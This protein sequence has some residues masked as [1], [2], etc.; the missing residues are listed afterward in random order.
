MLLNTE[1]LN[2]SVTVPASGGPVPETI[3]TPLPE[4]VETSV[5]TPPDMGEAVDNGLDPS[6]PRDLRTSLVNVTRR[7][8]ADLYPAIGTNAMGLFEGIRRS[9][10]VKVTDGKYVIDSLLAQGY[11]DIEQLVSAG[12]ALG[13]SYEEIYLKAAGTPRPYQSKRPPLQALP[14]ER[15]IDFAM[16][17]R[18]EQKH[19][20]VED[21]QKFVLSYTCDGRYEPEL[22]PYDSASVFEGLMATGD[23]DRA[24]DL[25]DFTT[26]QILKYGYPFNGM[27]VIGRNGDNPNDDPNY[28]AFRTQQPVYVY[29][30][31]GMAEA[32]GEEVLAHE[33]Y[34]QALEM[35]WDHFNP[36]PAL[37]N[38]RPFGKKFQALRRGGVSPE[39]WPFSVFGD[40]TNNGREYKDYTSAR[41]ESHLEDVE[42]ARQAAARVAP[43]YRERVFGEMLVHFAGAAE[44]GW[45]MSA[46]RQANGKDMS[47]ANTTNIVPLE[48]QCMLADMA[49]LLEHCY[50]IKREAAERSGNTLDAA[51]AYQREKY[52]KINRMGRKAFINKYMYNPKTRTFHDLELVGASS[53]YDK[54]RSYQGA[55]RTKV[56]SAATLHTLYSDITENADQALGVLDVAEQKLYQ[57]GGL[58]VGDLI[59]EKLEQWD[60]IAGWTNPERFGINGVVRAARRYPRHRL[61][62]LGSAIDLHARAQHGTNAAF[63]ATGTMVE[64]INTANPSKK[65]PRGEYP[66]DLKD[67]NTPRNFSMRG[68]HAILLGN[69]DPER[70]MTRNI[71]ARRAGRLLVVAP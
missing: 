4:V 11:T 25:L 38:S 9:S 58:A 8:P 35:L 27:R 42:L 53:S 3:D 16:R 5:F 14:G 59:P 63:E 1:S 66:K 21:G 20:V 51:D 33:P 30:L 31:R 6:A 56:I 28:Y 44:W 26:M 18:N 40:D 32:R 67:P 52:F 71:A 19:T 68:E 10:T 7:N 49:K 34:V 24:Q 43:E 13:L 47:Y 2:G 64:S 48:L 15:G 17:Q 46:S 55:R 12:L 61:R 22:Y 54:L 29:M 65:P 60:G 36:T 37:L 23:I 70:E 57:P 69:W 45:D 62:F 50:R 39:G 41:P